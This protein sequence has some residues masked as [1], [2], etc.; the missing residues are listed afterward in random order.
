MVVEDTKIV[1]KWR[2]H[3]FE[4]VI[5]IGSLGKNLFG[6]DNCL[7]KKKIVCIDDLKKRFLKRK[8][9]K[10]DLKIITNSLGFI[11]TYCW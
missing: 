4:T 7:K 3:F 10:K 8:C 2:V 9:V 11:G 5:L 6:E 1:D